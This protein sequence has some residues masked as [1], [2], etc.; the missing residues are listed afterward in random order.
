MI[1]VTRLQ[2]V[3][4]SRKSSQKLEIE[5]DKSCFSMKVGK[6]HQWAYRRRVLTLPAFFAPSPQ[7]DIADLTARSRKAIGGFAMLAS[8]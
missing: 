7:P 6:L 3:R 2:Q 1:T 5:L 4:F 8:P